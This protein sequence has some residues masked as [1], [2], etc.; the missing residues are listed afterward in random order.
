MTVG[1]TWATRGKGDRAL[2]LSGFTS[3]DVAFFW[4]SG[5]FL[6]TD[7]G[8][9]GFGN[10][11]GWRAFINHRAIAGRISDWTF[12]SEYED[13]THFLL[14]RV[15]EKDFYVGVVTLIDEV[16]RAEPDI[17][18]R[19]SEAEVVRLLRTGEKP[20]ESANRDR[21]VADMVCWLDRWG[22]STP[23]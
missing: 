14:A 18:P 20:G 9:T 11:D 1:H 4:S 16:L 10:A 21:A 6:W 2:F 3:W 22:S 23:T 12:G 15:P 7:M 5:S 8:G 17:S 13:G 19:A